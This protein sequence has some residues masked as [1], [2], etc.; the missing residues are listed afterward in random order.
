M[1]QPRSAGA[2]P[3]PFDFVHE[4]WVDAMQRT[5]LVLDALRQRGDTQIERAERLAPHVLTFEREVLVDG[6]TLPRPVNY[7]LLRITAPEGVVTD[8]RK[9][10]FVVFDPRAGH[11]PGIGGMKQDS[12]IGVALRAGHPCYFVGFMTDPVPGQTIEDV[13]RAE[14]HFLER[15]I[16]LHPEAEDKPCLI[17]NCQAGW[18]IMMMCAMRPDLPGPIMVAGAPLSYW[19]GKR[20]M[21]SMRYSGGLLGGSWLTAL[22]SDLGRGIFDGAHL[23]ANFEGMNPANTYWQKAYNVYSKVDT[24]AE[25]FLDFETWWGSPVTLNGEEIQFIVDELFIGNK[26]ASGGIASSEG[27]R[28]D[29]RNIRSPIIV[30]CS[31][32]DDITPPPQALG[33]LLDLYDTDEELAASGQTVVYTVHQSIGHLGIFVSG[34]VA[35]KEH[36]GFANAMDLIDMLPPGLYE[37]TFADIDEGTA[38]PGLIRG[39]YL[40]RLEGRRLDD[41]RALGVNGPEDERC[42]ETAAKVSEVN[43]ALYEQTMA[44]AVRALANDA[45]AEQLRRLHPHRLRF[46]AFSS[47]NPFLTAVPGLAGLARRHRQPVGPDNPLLAME[48]MMSQAVAGSLEAFGKARDAMA[49][50]LFLGIYGSPL[51]QAVVGL[52]PSRVHEGARGMRDLA[53]ERAAHGLR[54]ELERNMEHGGP[55]EAGVRGLFHVLRADRRMD[56]RAA[57]LLET[58]RAAQPAERH[59]PRERFRQVLREQALTLCLD[60]E[61]AVAA[62]PQLLPPDAQIRRRLMDIIRRVVEAQGAPSEEAERRLAHLEALFDAAR[63]ASKQPAPS[64]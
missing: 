45:A 28:V 62:I 43:R 50:S 18:Q 17:G 9:R 38:N 33:W 19:A 21:G 40:F 32:G 27:V 23:I 6:R 20:G 47:L 1:A 4:Y 37:A 16:A 52:D 63:P 15:V 11:G 44:P 64:H 7:A 5:V 56:E 22:T 46:E 24:E 34:K 57:A 60:E 49:E 61:R 41:I 42:F 54:A 13:C 59:I 2:F 29:L 14:V 3:S 39:E 25:R 53:R 30:F 31:W 51:L 48:R 8:P 10:P 55:L 58:L 35:T 12:E 36:A 26:L